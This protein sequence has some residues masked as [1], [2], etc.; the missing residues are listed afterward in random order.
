MT[1]SG[2][3]LTSGILI[4]AILLV[5]SCNE[6]QLSSDN[7]LIGTYNHNENHCVFLATGNEDAAGPWSTI[8]NGNTPVPTGQIPF[9][10]TTICFGTC[11]IVDDCSA[12]NGNY[13]IGYATINPASGVVTTLMA[14][15]C[16]SPCV[17]LGVTV[18]NNPTNGKITTVP[19]PSKP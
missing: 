9:F 7:T 17:G 11:R 3:L 18:P 12:A 13:L 19:T 8:P 2:M 16:T 14:Q 6:A 5:M 4:A 10:P 15:A 1:R